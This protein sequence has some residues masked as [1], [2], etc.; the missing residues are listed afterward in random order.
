MPAF[1]G[2]VNHVGQRE[3]GLDATEREGVWITKHRGSAFPE[4]RKSRMAYRVGEVD[5]GG[6]MTLCA[7]WG[8]EGGA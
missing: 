2:S 4:G 8:I 1:C 5:G 7:G 6:P 3:R